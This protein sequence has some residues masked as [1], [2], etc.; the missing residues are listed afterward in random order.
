[1]KTTNLDL[2][3]IK[4]ADVIGFSGRSWTGAVINLGTYGIPLWGLSH[5]GIM[6]HAPD[7]RL[8]L[9]E[10]TSLDT[11]IPCEITGKPIEGTQAHTLE[12]TL[13]RYVG[14]LWHYPLYR[15]LY[16]WEDQRLTDFLVGTIGV[17]YDMMGAFRSAG[18]GLSFIE[19]LFRPQDLT[20]IFCSEYVMAAFSH[21]GIHPTDHVSRWSPNRLARR[22]RRAGILCKPRRLR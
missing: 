12:S 20:S 4:P 1:M 19:S 22:L 18:I 7:G 3:R 14:T 21:L 11:V 6:G 10:S 15:P 13:A 8:L 17:P 5:I 16:E 2:Y 9:F